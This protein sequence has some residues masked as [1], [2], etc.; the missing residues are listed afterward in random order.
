M[1]CAA[2]PKCNGKKTRQGIC[3]QSEKGRVTNKTTASSASLLLHDVSHDSFCLD[4]PHF[5][6]K[7]IFS[8]LASNE[9]DKKLT[10]G[11]VYNWEL[12]SWLNCMCGP[13]SPCTSTKIQAVSFQPGTCRKEATP[14]PSFWSLAQG[15]C[16]QKP[17]HPPL[18]YLCQNSKP[19]HSK[20]HCQHS[21][22]KSE[23]HKYFVD[24]K[25]LPAAF[26][27]FKFQEHTP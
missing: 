24:W 6:V 3:I 12:I 19:F 17:F 21:S 9:A 11:H 10:S 5:T 13:P 18:K 15:Q 23:T 4:S 7:R 8:A 27:N 1:K 26:L 25:S 16:H 14:P 20:T 22:N 2:E